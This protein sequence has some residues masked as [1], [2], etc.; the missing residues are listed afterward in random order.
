V[1]GDSVNLASRLEGRS[2]AYG[3][4]IIVG[5]RTAKAAF[6]KFAALEIDFITVK[7]KTEPETIFTILGDKDVAE[8]A[9]FQK[10][11]ALN[12]QMLSCYRMRDWTAAIEAVQLCRAARNS[13][14]LAEV[15]DL[16]RQRIETFRTNP[17]PADWDGVFA[18][19]SK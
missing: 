18:F 5:A 19:D 9:E 8:G 2:K 11:H 3:T 15:Y 10:L 7:G 1:L 4:P 14:A 16:Y 17:P 13:F 6:G 12:T